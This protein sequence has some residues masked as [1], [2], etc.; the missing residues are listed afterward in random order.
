MK[1]FCLFTAVQTVLQSL[2]DPETAG[3]ILEK[4]AS[5]LKNIL[6]DPSVLKLIRAH[7]KLEEG[8]KQIES[9]DTKLLVKELIEEMDPKVAA[10]DSAAELS[11]LL[12]EPHF[13]VIK[14]ADILTGKK[15]LK[16]SAFKECVLLNT[17]NDVDR[18][19]FII[20]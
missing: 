6:G 8:R 10:D 13:L 20:I 1:M 15:E 16:T 12:Q 5:A 18:V 3:L 17:F 19:D 2:D 9:Q 4:E 11:G 7:D 14:I